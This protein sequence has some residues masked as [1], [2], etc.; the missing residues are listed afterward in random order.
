VFERFTKDARRVVTAA[1]AEARALD[2]EA[3]APEHLLLGFVVAA[4]GGS[5]LASPPLVFSS[6]DEPPRVITA[7]ALRAAI[8]REEAEALARLGISL[9]AVREQVEQNLGAD[10]W[11]TGSR[12]GHLPFTSEAKQ[13]LE[14]ALRETLELRQ[15]RLTGQHV[16]LGLLRQGRVS[17]LLDRVGVS[18]EEVGSRIRASL[19]GAAALARR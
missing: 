8:A 2:A 18:A 19:V 16:L 13:A 17:G 3:V 9:E 1:E 5:W 6:F 10:A 12:H 7:E 15:R 14:L 4:C 11:S